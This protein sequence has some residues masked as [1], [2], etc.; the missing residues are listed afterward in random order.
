[1]SGSRFVFR[2]VGKS[3]GGRE[4]LCDVSLTVA[5]GDNLAILGSSG[6]GKSTV[7]RLLAGLEV[8]DAGGVFLN[9]RAVSGPGRIVLAPHRRGISLVF[10]DLALWPN[11]SARE[12]VMMGLSGLPRAEARARTDEVLSLCGIEELADRKPG[13]MS[14]GQQQ[15]VALARAVAV[16]PTFL[17]L[18]EPYA[19]F[20][21]VLKS[22]LLAEVRA[23]AAAQNTTIVLVTHDPFEATAALCRSAVIL[24]RGRVAEAGPFTALLQAPRLRAAAAFRDEL[25]RHKSKP[26]SECVSQDDSEQCSVCCV[27][28]PVGGLMG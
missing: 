9:D 25:N 26:E 16:R 15:R 6:S 28:D 8:P 23:L 12:N 21:L 20:D 22:R 11:L 14:G 13:T 1:M 24:D 18:D 5:T 7:L 2:S 10:Q 27:N 3:Y 4:A 19:G 17:L